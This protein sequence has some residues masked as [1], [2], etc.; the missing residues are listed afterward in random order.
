MRFKQ[1][2]IVN[3]FLL[4]TDKFTP[5]VHVKQPGFTYSTCKPFTKK[6]KTNK[7]KNTK[8]KR[9]RRFTIY[10]SKWTR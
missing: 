6:K 8:I 5:E 4:P 3:M 7:K 9:Y 10:L 2:E 1:N